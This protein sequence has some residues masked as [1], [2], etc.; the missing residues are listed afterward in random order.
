[1]SEGE[2]LGAYYTR[3]FGES[4]EDRMSVLFTHEKLPEWHSC[5]A[6]HE[7]NITIYLAMIY[8]SRNNAIFEL[9]S[10]K[11]IQKVSMENST[12]HPLNGF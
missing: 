1:M 6:L 10:K 12:A 5:F 3:D 4:W 9:T 11:A 2:Q 8:A 7:H